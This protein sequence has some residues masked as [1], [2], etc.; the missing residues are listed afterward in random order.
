MKKL[1]ENLLLEQDIFKP[2]TEKELEQ[3]QIEVFVKKYNGKLNPDGSYDFDMS[4]RKGNLRNVIEDGRFIIKFGRVGGNFVCSDNK[5]ISLEGAP[6]YVNGWFDCSNNQLISLKGAPKYVGGD[7]YCEYNNL[8]SLKGAPERV[9]GSFICSYNNLTSLEGAPKYV[10]G[11]FYCRH[12][13]LTSLEGAPKYVG[14]NF[15]CSDNPVK[16]TEEEVRKVSEVKGKII[17]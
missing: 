17:V 9:E 16:F 13:K 2:P 14:G 8:T 4:L 15:G 3:R 6:K 12:N 7:F 11:S 10:G 5:L 1:L